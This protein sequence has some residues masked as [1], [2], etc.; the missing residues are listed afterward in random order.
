[1]LQETGQNHTRV[2][3]LSFEQLFLIETKK[4]TFSAILICVSAVGWFSIHLSSRDR[5]GQTNEQNEQ[6]ND[7]PPDYDSAVRGTVSTPDPKLRDIS[8]EI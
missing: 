3:T 4:A 2:F 6:A 5:N 1:M 7:S 8:R